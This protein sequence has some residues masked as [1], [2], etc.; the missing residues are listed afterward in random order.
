MLTAALSQLAAK[1]SHPELAQVPVVPFG[2]SAAGVLSITLAGQLPA[3]VATVVAYASGSGY[4]NLDQVAVTPATGVI[5]ML[6]LASADDNLAGDARSLRFFERGRTIGAPWAFAAQNGTDHC[7]TLSTRPLMLPWITAIVSLTQ[8]PTLMP[9]SGAL[10]TFN[11]TANAVIDS[12]GEADCAI[13]S[14]IAVP[15]TTSPAN[16][17]GT[18]WTPDQPTLNAWMAWVTNSGRN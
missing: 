3:R 11:C 17:A 18:I 12:M 13:T 4:T 16:P 2:F 5:P 9:A 8:K 15:F 6:I 10:A 7:C 1:T 14:P